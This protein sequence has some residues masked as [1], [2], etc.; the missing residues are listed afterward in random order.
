MLIELKQKD[1]KEKIFGDFPENKRAC[2]V[3]LSGA[4]RAHATSGT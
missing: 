1:A 2:R 3:A 4:I